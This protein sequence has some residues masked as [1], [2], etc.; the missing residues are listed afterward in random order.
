MNGEIED[1]YT[2]ARAIAKKA[3]ENATAVD[4]VKA[5]LG[6]VSSSESH[7]K[8]DRMVNKLTTS[9]TDKQYRVTASPT[10]EAAA[11]AP[12]ADGGPKQ[13][14]RPK[15]SRKEK[16]KAAEE[17]YQ[18]LIHRFRLYVMAPPTN[19]AAAAAPGADGG[20]KQDNGA[21]TS[22]KCAPERSRKAKAKAAEEDVEHVT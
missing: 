6:N 17:G 7:S 1:L 16:A 13:D 12:G 11:A 14:N 21:S 9:W 20:P 4:T 19:E 22:R 2:K 8:I 10:N 3:D 5:A 15:K 18:A